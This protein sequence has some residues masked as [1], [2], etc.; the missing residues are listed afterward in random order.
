[1]KKTPGLIAGLLV[2]VLLA[3]GCGTRVAATVNGEKIT[4]AELNKRVEQAAAWYGYDLKSP[5]N[6]DLT[7][8]LQ[9]QVLE[10]LVMEKVVRQAAG[11]MKIEVKKEEIEEELKKIRDQLKTEENYADFL[12]KRKFTEK[13][14]QTYIGN[15]LLL[16]KLFGE[17]TKDITAPSRDSRQ[18]YE[19][20]KEEFFVKEQVKARNIVVKTEE[21]AKNIISRLGSGEDFA[22]LAAELSID[23]TA[24]ETGGL[25]DYF[26][27]DAMYIQEFKDAAFSLKAGQYT[28][29][30]V[31]TVYGYHIIKVEDRKPARQYSFE[32][33]KDELESRL[34]MEEKNEKFLTYVDD[35][36]EK[37]NIERKLLEKEPQAGSQ[38]QPE[39]QE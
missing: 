2:L 34:L 15:Q 33:I 37:A 9:E 31:K 35:L 4:E 38:P 17:V 36:I 1:M 14:L 29:T 39:N 21:E 23:P 25:I 6:K 10:S 26:D 24:K 18:Y 32:E 27:R 22:K 11:E 20:H 8:Q 19:E 28:K 3:A 16:D 13:D 12:K 30:P 7:A 5:E